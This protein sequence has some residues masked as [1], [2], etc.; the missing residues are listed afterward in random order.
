MTKISEVDQVSRI[1]RATDTHVELFDNGVSLGKVPVD[2][3]GGWTK[4]A[5]NLALGI[6]TYTAKAANGMP[7]SEPWEIQVQQVQGDGENFDAVPD[8]ILSRGQKIDLPTMTI[9]FNGGDGLIG[10]LPFNYGDAYDQPSEP[11]RRE[12]KALH[13][14]INRQGGIQTVTLDLNGVYSKVSFWHSYIE[15]RTSATFYDADGSSLGKILLTYSLDV[16]RQ[17]TFSGSNIT[18]IVFVTSVNDA[19]LLDYLKFE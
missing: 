2:S 7:A 8:T 11:E 1:A 18:K 4:E 6:H 12:G 14:N 15:T 19:T 9:T 13:M 17:I 3:Q 16:P 10:I 5:S